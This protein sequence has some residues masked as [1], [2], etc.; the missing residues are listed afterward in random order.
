MR[1]RYFLTHSGEEALRVEKSGY[2]EDFR[3]ALWPIIWFFLLLCVDIP[4]EYWNRLISTAKLKN[5]GSTNKIPGKS[6][7][8]IEYCVRGI[9]W[10]KSPTSNSPTKSTSTFP[11]LERRTSSPSLA[12]DGATWWSFRQWPI[13]D[14]VEFDAPETRHDAM[15]IDFLK[16]IFNQR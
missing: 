5:N 16:N 3:L 15:N 4:F 6:I 9:P 2:P 8:W 7:C 14:P 12:G 10:T 13:S 11:V 1:P